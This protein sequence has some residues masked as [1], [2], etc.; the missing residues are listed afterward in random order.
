VT[1]TLRRFINR[2]KIKSGDSFMTLRLSFFKT[3]T[4]IALFVLFAFTFGISAQ[5]STAANVSG[6]ASEIIRSGE[7][8]ASAVSRAKTLGRSFKNLFGKNKNRNTVKT[9]QTEKEPKR[10]DNFVLSSPVPTADRS[11][12]D[13]RR[14]NL[15]KVNRPP[16]PVNHDLDDEDRYSADSDEN[17]FIRISRQ[18]RP[19]IVK[20]E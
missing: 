10:D 15:A 18:M 8:A 7:A 12:E 2:Q 17:I 9:D 14:E 11:N 1:G 5:T 3:A 6:A 20:I 19:R 16:L 4:M 13:I